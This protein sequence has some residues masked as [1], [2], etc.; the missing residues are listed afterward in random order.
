MRVRPEGEG[1][2]LPAVLYLARSLEEGGGVR[3]RHPARAQQQHARQ[4]GLPLLRE[5][6]VDAGGVAVGRDGVQVRVVDLQ[7]QVLD[8]GALADP[9]NMGRF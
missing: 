1:V 6:Q 7:D 3:G 9:G 5:L 2:D 8:V 4:V